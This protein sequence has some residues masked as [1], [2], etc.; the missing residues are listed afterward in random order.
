[1]A[2]YKLQMIEQNDVYFEH[3]PFIN[4]PWGRYILPF[5]KLLA[6]PFC[7]CVAVL[8]VI[9]VREYWTNYWRRRRQD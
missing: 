2:D 3:H 8:L 5:F 9:M 1:M 6:Y 4:W 7:F